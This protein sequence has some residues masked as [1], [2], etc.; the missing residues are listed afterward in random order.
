M[1]VCLSE[2]EKVRR[3]E[4]A[5]QHLSW[6]KTE[7][8]YYNHQVD[9]AQAAW[10]SS[11]SNP[12]IAY[13]SY[14]F[15]QQ[16]H[17]PYDAQQTGPMYFKTARKC[18]LFGVS[19]DGKKQQVLYLIDEAE[20]PGKGADCV[21]SLLHHYLGQ[22]SHGEKCVYL[23]ADNCVGQNKNNASMQYHMWRVLTGC[24]ESIEL[25][26]MLVGHTKFSP[27]RYFGFLKA[28]FRCSSVSSVSIFIY[29]L[30]FSIM[31]PYAIE[32]KMF[33]K[34]YWK[35]SSLNHSSLLAIIM[36]N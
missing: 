4:S 23:H 14:D 3:L 18:G 1:S 17:Y 30:I 9:A 7:R 13:C 16:I 11:N 33:S 32:W 19:N 29:M 25:S 5:Q 20:N 8:E 28:A 12:R 36:L 10:K 35:E 15:A 24:E 2:E 31:F 26:F 21:I 6:T 27:D 34:L 22:Y